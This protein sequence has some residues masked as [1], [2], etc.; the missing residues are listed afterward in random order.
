[1]VDEDVVAGD[2]GHLLSGLVRL[3][4]R[5]LVGEAVECIDHHPVACRQYRRAVGKVILDLA[6]VAVPQP[7]MLVDLDEVDGK[8]LPGMEGSVEWNEPIT[9]VARR[10]RTAALGRDPTPAF[11]RWRM[12]GDADPDRSIAPAVVL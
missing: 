4:T 3:D 5:L 6:V 8:T 2:L 10:V 9:M 11:Q 1:M 7:A 12:T